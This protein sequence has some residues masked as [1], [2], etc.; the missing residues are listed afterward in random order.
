MKPIK[1][2][3]NEELTIATAEE[4]MEWPRDQW[5]WDVENWQ[6]IIR[7]DYWMMVVER[8]VESRWKCAVYIS[9][10]NPLQKVKFS[11]PERW[12]NRVAEHAD[13]GRAVC[14]AALEAIRG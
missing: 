2:M 5:D 6:P 8:M 4:V 14:E 1:E 13:I 10:Y 9:A 7:P 12:F 3:S 11:H